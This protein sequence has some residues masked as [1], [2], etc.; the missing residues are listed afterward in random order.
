MPTP[1]P[2]EFISLGAIIKSFHV[3]KT[4]VV[5]GFSSQDLYITHNSPHFGEN[6]GRVAN[7]IANAQINSLNQKSYPLAKNDGVNSLHG[8]VVG[9][10][11]KIWDGPTPVGKRETGVL[12]LLQDSSECVVFKLRSK[13][14]DEGY[15]GSVEAQVFYTT[16]KQYENGK[17]INLLIMEYEVFFS[18]DD[19]S[20]IEETVVNMTNHSYGFKDSSQGTKANPNLN[21]YFNIS[22]SS[23]IDGT[24]VTLS[25]NTHLPVDDGGIPIST[26]PVSCSSFTANKPFTLGAIEP[27]FDH[28]FIVD[29]TPGL[30]IPL[31]SRSSPLKLLV[32]AFHPQTKIHLEVFSTEPAFQFYTGQHIDVPAVEGTPAR[33]SRAGFCVE[34]SRY[35]DAINREEWRDQVILKKGQVYGS[36]IVYKAWSDE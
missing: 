30:Q 2:C 12:P 19:T 7:R 28:C 4:N 3:G 35:I 26:T 17:E 36:R 33:G 1:P 24:I 31:D 29:P 9:W 13:D 15:P 32:T 16:G 27:N 8:G 34:P 10:G 11:K 6:I 18:E 22:G 14:G 20:E 5:L 25:S 23:T 21:S